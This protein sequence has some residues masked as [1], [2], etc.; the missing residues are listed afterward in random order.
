MLT[1]ILDLSTYWHKY[2]AS[3]NLDARNYYLSDAL[4]EI[5]SNNTQG[6]Y[7]TLISKALK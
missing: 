7:S 5:K 4:L 3:S 6:F 2:S 1:D